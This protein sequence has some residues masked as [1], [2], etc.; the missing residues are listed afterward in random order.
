MLGGGVGRLQGLRGLTSDAVRK[1]R[2]VLW[3]GTIIE[4]SDTANQDLFWGMRGAG[5]NFGV[6]YETVF[7]TW[8]ATNGGLNYESLL[9]FGLDAVGP[10]VDIINSLMPID[11]A[12]AIGFVGGSNPETLEVSLPASSKVKSGTPLIYYTDPCCSRPGLC[13]NSGKGQEVYKS[14]QELQ[15]NA[16]R[17]DDLL[18]GFAH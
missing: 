11:P 10:I 15:H 12:L 5:Q 16:Y 1:I 9:T 3:N 18:C 7:E 8:P 6:V 14:V 17:V 2:M 4:A 13:R